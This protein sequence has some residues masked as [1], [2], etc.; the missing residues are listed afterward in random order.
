VPGGATMAQ[1]ALRWILM[2][3]SVSTVI[4]G[5][6]NAAQ[7]IANSQASALDAILPAAMEQLRA[8]YRE[9]IAPHVHHL[10]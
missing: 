8:L 10:W 5:A 7:A 9:R 1:F 4:P 2:E 3:Q 6:R